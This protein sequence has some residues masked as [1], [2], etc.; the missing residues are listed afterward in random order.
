MLPP[1]DP[2]ESASH[3]VPIFNLNNE[4][5]AEANGNTTKTII[6]KHM[7]SYKP[8]TSESGQPERP[9]SNPCLSGLSRTEMP[10]TT[11]DT[12]HSIEMPKP[13]NTNIEYSEQKAHTYNITKDNK[14]KDKS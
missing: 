7:H 4:A 8:L 1:V 3:H 10:K 5:M 11:L 6:R 14:T 13:F 12:S 2:E 9:R